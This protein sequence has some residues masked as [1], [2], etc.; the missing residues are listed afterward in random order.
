MKSAR[1]SLC[2]FLFITAL[3][4]IVQRSLQAQTA[5]GSGYSSYYDRVSFATTS[6][7][8]PVTDYQMIDPSNKIQTYTYNSSRPASVYSGD[9]MRDYDNKWDDYSHDPNVLESPAVDVHWAL[10][11]TQFMWRGLGLNS[12]DNAGS[13]IVATINFPLPDIERPVSWDV[14]NKYIRFD[15]ADNVIYRSPTS[16][17]AVAHEFTHAVIQT[18]PGKGEAFP[19]GQNEERALSEGFADMFGTAVEFYTFPRDASDFRAPNWTIG[20]DIYIDRG[21]I[22]DLSV[23]RVTYGTS[24]WIG[25][26]DNYFRGSVISHAFYLMAHGGSGTNGKNVPYNVT[27]IGIDKAK[28]IAFYVLTQPPSGQT[29]AWV[30]QNDFNF[31][32][33]RDRFLYWALAL[34][35]DV[36]GVPSA[37]YTST[38]NA[39]IAVGLDDRIGITVKNNFP[40]GTIK[41]S[42]VNNNQPITVPSDGYPV[43]TTAGSS[44]TIEAISP[45][46]GIGTPPYDRVWNVN[47]NVLS[48]WKK[49]LVDGTEVFPPGGENQAFPFTLSS[50]DNNTTYIADMKKLY[51]ISRNDQTDFDGTFA[52][53]VVSQIVEQNSGTVT[54][55]SQQT[56]NGKDF[57]FY[58]W[59]DGDKNPSKTVS[60]VDN[61]TLT[62]YYKAHLLSS[63]S[64]ALSSNSQRKLVRDASGKLSLTYESAS[65]I[66]NTT[67]TDNGA[68]WSNESVVGNLPTATSF[69]RNPTLA[70]EADGS[71]V[72]KVYE[73]LLDA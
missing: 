66:W 6:V 64:A 38:L 2:T 25:D 58:Q 52:A 7:G 71:T 60:P 73:G 49:R 18:Y 37:E 5:Y 43:F 42:S 9:I 32:K 23:L 22:R 27:G 10:S 72:S 41:I 12:W 8:N 50:S 21:Y 48:K 63:S 45:Q 55:P 53:G 1:V 56:I 69:Y 13:Y 16:L 31:I 67:S 3:H 28:R 26:N 65:A 68:T 59:S 24:R 47:G 40:G 29:V 51:K 34:Y 35:P 33:V 36:N 44:I 14:T 70:L 11:Q 17:D 46:L 39:M 20:E 30:T 54:A 57:R 15:A 62:A 4:F 61:T 19:Q